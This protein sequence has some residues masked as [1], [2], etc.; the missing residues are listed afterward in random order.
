MLLPFGSGACETDAHADRSRAPRAPGRARAC[1][2]WPAPPPAGAP[3]ADVLGPALAGGVDVFQLRE[4]DAREADLLAAAAVARALCDA[5]GALFILND[6]PDLVAADAAPTACT[7]ARTT[8]RSRT[9]ASSPA[10]A[11]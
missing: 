2:S 7:S 4:K 10:A 9:P 8:R 11:R 6:R 5:A 1:I 3:L